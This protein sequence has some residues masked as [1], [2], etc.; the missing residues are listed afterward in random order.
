MGAEQRREGARAQG[1]HL[2]Q[3]EIVCTSLED[4]VMPWGSGGDG[5][6]L[7]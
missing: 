7:K 1:G 4:H 6:S 2:P 5:K 3:R